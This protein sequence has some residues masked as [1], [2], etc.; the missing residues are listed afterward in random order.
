MGLLLALL[1]AVTLPVLAESADEAARTLARRLAPS[2]KGQ[3]ISIDPAHPQSPVFASALRGAGVRLSREG[4][5]LTIETRASAL[6]P[7]LLAHVILEGRREMAVEPF[8]SVEAPNVYL[9]ATPEFVS[10]QPFLDTVTDNG[11][12]YVLEPGGVALMEKGNR[13]RLWSLD[14]LV[15]VHR[16]PSGSLH[17]L[18]NRLLVELNGKHCELTLDG[19]QP[20]SFRCVPAPATPSRALQAPCLSKSQPLEAEQL[21]HEVQFRISAAAS[22]RLTGTLINLSMSPE[23]SQARAVIRRPA[24]E[25]GEGTSK[26]TVA[27]GE[28]YEAWR[29][30]VTCVP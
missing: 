19:E 9:T 20:G 16:A 26:D 4:A 21:P 8:E 7:V 2:L 25:R 12:R 23:G 17:L 28:T 11:N 18:D 30:M 1:L 27:R 22:L 13:T 6:G 29:L 3:S 15:P 5:R 24:P 10:R 14:A